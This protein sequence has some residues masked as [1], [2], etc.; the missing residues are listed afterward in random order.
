MSYR[1]NAVFT[2]FEKLTTSSKLPESPMQK[3]IDAI[4]NSPAHKCGSFP[5]KIYKTVF[6]SSDFT[7]E[8][9]KN[10]ENYILE[11][12]QERIPLYFHDMTIQNTF[13]QAIKLHADEYYLFVCRTIYPEIENVIF[14]EIL[15]KDP[16]WFNNLSEGVRNNFKTHEHFKALLNI[17]KVLR[18]DPNKPNKP[19]KKIGIRYPQIY[20]LERRISKVGF[21]NIHFIKALCQ[22]F[23]KFDPL[24]LPHDNLTA[25]RN[26]YC[27][28][29]SYKADFMDS[30]NSLLL[31]DM[32][33]QF[34]TEYK[35]SLKQEI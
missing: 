26:L 9:I 31:L 8:D 13:K 2:Q 6:K 1:I 7:I 33:L 27:H 25:K 32:T 23:D 16:D 34:I 22:T 3:M 28:G 29:V 12:L 35:A 24:S 21:Y 5:H 14:T 4:W 30:L 10:K 17:E 20:D 15:K 19:K 11:A 18:E